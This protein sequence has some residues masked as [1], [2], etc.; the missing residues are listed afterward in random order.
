MQEGERGLVDLGHFLLGG[1][2]PM[3]GWHK[4]KRSLDFRFPEVGLSNS[5]TKLGH[6]NVIFMMWPCLG[7]TDR[8]MP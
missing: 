7:E 5:D 3:T 6:D 1:N 2:L 4:R 8:N